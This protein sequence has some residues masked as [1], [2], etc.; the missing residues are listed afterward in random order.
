MREEIAGGI[1]N[2]VER[3][4]PLDQVKQSFI[5]AGYPAEEVDEA[6][7]F[8]SGRTT[9]IISQPSSNLSSQPIINSESQ[10]SQSQSS[11]SV[12]QEK[13]RQLCIIKILMQN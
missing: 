3:G 9:S 2:A 13:R 4:I 5:A 7:A 12:Q 8:I 11:Q 6:A 1:K 10:S